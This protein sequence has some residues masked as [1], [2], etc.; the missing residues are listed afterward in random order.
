[1]T[2]TDVIPHA[3]HYT[4]EPFLKQVAVPQPERAAAAATL[5]TSLPSRIDIVFEMTDNSVHV[6]WI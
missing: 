6:T 1:M 3:S 2:G 4:T 5:S